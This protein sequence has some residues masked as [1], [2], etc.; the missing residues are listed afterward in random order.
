MRSVA[1]AKSERT[2]GQLARAAHGD[3]AAFAELVA[4]HHTHMRRVA[5][6]VCRDLDMAED[7]TQQAW[8][9]AWRRLSSVRDE[10]RL[11][12]W[13]VAVAANEA[14]KLL[15]RRHRRWVVEVSL[16]PMEPAA[17]DPQ[18]SARVDLARALARLDPED[19]ELLALR[20]V[21]GLDSFEIARLR[22]R[23]ASGTRARLGRLLTRLR[24][25]L[26]DG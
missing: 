1:V 13:L 10:T 14:R 8:H 6:V 21:A 11:R 25:E 17:R 22:G 24:R 20:Y 3:H 9:I 18:E 23:S 7:A 5:Y 2:E 26:E 15:G 16:T 19:R 4:S 12:A